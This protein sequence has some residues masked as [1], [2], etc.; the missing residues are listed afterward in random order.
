MDA[1]GTDKTS[2]GTGQPFQKSEQG[3]CKVGLSFGC[4]QLAVLYWL[5]KQNG[6]PESQQSL[7]EHDNMAALELVIPFL[8]PTFPSVFPLFF[9]LPS[10]ALFISFNPTFAM[11]LQSKKARRKAG[12]SG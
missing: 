11:L 7:D 5:S 3:H 2:S 6:S 8:L 4:P 12:Y 1:L 10:Q 9:L